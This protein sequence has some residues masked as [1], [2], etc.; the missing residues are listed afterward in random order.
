MKKHN[1]YYSFFNMYF[2]TAFTNNAFAALLAL[3]GKMSRNLSW[4]E[5][6]IVLFSI[7]DQRS[8]KVQCQ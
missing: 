1:I 7:M 2:N 6:R 3:I 5:Y 8:M 4:I